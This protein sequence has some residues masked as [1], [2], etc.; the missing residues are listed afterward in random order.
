MTAS[1]PEYTPEMDRF[2]RE[3]L[4]EFQDALTASIDLDRKLVEVTD[5]VARVSSTAPPAVDASASG[6]EEGSKESSTLAIAVS[7]RSCQF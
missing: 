4:A 6:I 5:E 1:E 2:V 7:D 3:G